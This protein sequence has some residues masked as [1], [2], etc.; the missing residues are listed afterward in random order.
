ML[1]APRNQTVTKLECFKCREAMCVQ[2]HVPWHDSTSISWPI[3]NLLT[4]VGL[5]LSC[6]EYQVYLVPGFGTYLI[7]PKALPPDERSHEDRLMLKLIQVIASLLKKPR[8]DSE[9]NP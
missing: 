7:L 5:E 8:V 6:T 1:Q 2:C 3:F 9:F 4:T